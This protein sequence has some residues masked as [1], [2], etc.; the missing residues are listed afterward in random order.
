MTHFLVLCVQEKKTPMGA[1]NATQEDSPGN[2][3]PAKDTM[4]KLY[5]LFKIG[6]SKKPHPIQREISI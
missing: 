1:C 4:Q 3:Y 5:T 2:K 6:I